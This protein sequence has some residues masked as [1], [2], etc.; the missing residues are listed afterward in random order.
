MALA[1]RPAPELELGLEPALELGLEPALELGLEP[2][3]ELGLEPALA[4]ARPGEDGGVG[5]RSGT[6]RVRAPTR[7]ARSLLARRSTSRHPSEATTATAHNPASTSI[8]D[9]KPSVPSPMAWAMA[10]GQLP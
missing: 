6:A 8:H 1:W 5:D 10:N 2:A 3:L 4:C 7:R 9:L